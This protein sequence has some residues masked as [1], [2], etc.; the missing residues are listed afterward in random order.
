MYGRVFTFLPILRLRE[1]AVTIEFRDFIFKL[2]F[3]LH[4]KIEV[5]SI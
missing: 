5:F 2:E 1:L 3:T 4:P